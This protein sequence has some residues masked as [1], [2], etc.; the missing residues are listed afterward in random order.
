GELVTLAQEM[1]LSG[2]FKPK[3]PDAWR[4]IGT[5]VPKV[6]TVPKT[7]GTAIY[8][9]DVKL[10]D[11]LTCVIARPSRFAAKAQ[12]FDPAPA[13]AVPGVKEVF[14]VPEGVAVLADG[15]WAA[16]KGR[17]ALTIAWDESGTEARSSEAIAKEYLELAA[18]TGAVARNDGDA[19][20][21]ISGAAKVIEATYV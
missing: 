10:P 17:D 19:E 9:I 12:S 4:L 20:K 3:T 14:A 2:P 1:E 13:L 16:K 5:K 8:T 7:N 11:M 18:S 15:F 21:A 6:D